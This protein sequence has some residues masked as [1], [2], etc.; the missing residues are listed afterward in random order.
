[1]LKNSSLSINELQ[2]HT[3]KNYLKIWKCGIPFVS[4]LYKKNK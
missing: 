3:Q 1:M 4:L 2:K